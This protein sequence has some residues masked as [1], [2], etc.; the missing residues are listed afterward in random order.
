MG[1]SSQVSAGIIQELQVHKRQIFTALGVLVCP[2]LMMNY[3]DYK[4]TPTL[5]LDNRVFAVSY[6][7]WSLVMTHRMKLLKDSKLQNFMRINGMSKTAFIAKTIIANYIF[8]MIVGGVSSLR[9]ALY[10]SKYTS[11]DSSSLT[12]RFLNVHLVNAI[13]VVNLCLLMVELLPEEYVLFVAALWF[14]ILPALSVIESLEG[15]ISILNPF[16]S[17]NMNVSN[18][19]SSYYGETLSKMFSFAMIYFVLY[20]CLKMMSFMK[21]RFKT[22]VKQSKLKE[23][24]L[25]LM[26]YDHQLL[27][28]GDPE[29][30]IG[31][32]NNLSSAQYEEPTPLLNPKKVVIQVNE[33]GMRYQRT[34]EPALENVTFQIYEGE[35]F[36]LL[37]YN[38]AGKT[39]LLSILC[40]LISQTEGTFQYDDNQGDTQFLGFCSQENLIFVNNTIHENF[41]LM[42]RLKNVQQ[43]Q[44]N[45]R[46]E[47]LLNQFD[48]K[49]LQ[50]K[51]VSGLHIDER[52]KLSLALALLNNP[53]III[54]DEPTSELDV[55]TRRDFW[56]R[57]KELKQNGKT[58]IFTTQFLDDAEALADRVAILA[59]GGLY[60]LGSVDYMKKTFGTGYTLVISNS[61]NPA[62]LA[63]QASQ[64]NKLVEKILPLAELIS[65]TTLNILKYALSLSDRSKFPRLLKELES[66]PNIQ[67]NLQRTSLEDA[68]KGLERN[69]RIK[70]SK[71][72]DE[73]EN[74]SHLDSFEDLL[75][76]KDYE[77]GIVKQIKAVIFQRVC[78]FKQERNQLIF[79]IISTILSI[80]VQRIL[81][82]YRVV[83]DSTL[84]GKV[85]DVIN[86]AKPVMSFLIIQLSFL[87]LF[88]ALDMTR[89]RRK[90]QTTII[91]ILGLKSLSY[92]SGNL[93]FDLIVLLP[94]TLAFGVECIFYEFKEEALLMN[95]ARIILTSICIIMF[96][97]SCSSSGLGMNA[98]GLLLSIPLFGFMSYAIEV[99]YLIIENAEEQKIGPYL[100]Y[101]LIVILI[102]I[103]VLLSLLAGVFP[104][105]LINNHLSLLFFSCVIQFIAIHYREEFA[106]F[107]GLRKFEGTPI[108]DGDSSAIS[109]V[110]DLDSN[111]FIRQERER[112]FAQNNQDVINILG[113]EKYYA[114]YEHVRERQILK[115]IN[116]G[117]E[118]GQI[119]CLLGPN[120]SG[121]TL[122][123]DVLNRRTFL[124]L[125]LIKIKGQYVGRKSCSK[126]ITGACLQSDSHWDT[127][128]V[129]QNLMVIAYSRGMNEKEASDWTESLMRALDLKRHSSTEAWHLS[130]GTRRKLSVA[131]A[132]IGGPELVL[133]DSPTTGVDPAGRNQI[134]TLLKKLVKVK[135]ST[136][137][138]S[139][140]YT[141]DAELVADK[142]GIIVNGTMMT[143][144]SISALR[145]SHLM[146]FILIEKVAEGFMKNLIEI[147][148]GVI[149]EAEPETKDQ[150][151][152][153]QVP[154]T[155]MKFG[156]IVEQLE[157]LSTNKKISDFSINVKTLEQTFMAYASEQVK[158]ELYSKGTHERALY[159]KPTLEL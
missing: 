102:L 45:Q 38:G 67:I 66:I 90:D 156:R 121:K 80:L 68:F 154:S 76:K 113:G 110:D 146:H 85:Y 106:K 84:K 97:Y 65:E 23:L 151:V 104:G 139:T 142:L 103:T 55:V 40:G 128:S 155:A 109:D 130:A 87:V 120:H 129:K 35:I 149:P 2:I 11:S 81:D 44:F 74:K 78:R 95:L 33:I 145:K 57:I 28:N 16:V 5:L 36:C 51:V 153:F 54:L 79:L 59:N 93:I 114:P 123:F 6:F 30:F 12:I 71:N 137:L 14:S 42:A 69:F 152:T 7:A 70:D 92:Y 96:S 8:T 58:V 32:S 105:P 98:F 117:V 112:V 101:F 50:H 60:A 88:S 136:V 72:Q 116:F 83:P 10:F 29:S 1:F 122:I 27:L 143:L 82:A 61:V 94:L 53:N 56:E 89:N 77:T 132:L 150:G 13:A 20:L 119:F 73:Y 41:K 39:T 24:D 26:N 21:E 63:N 25:P 62:E 125:G 140:H 43:E 18:I 126:A 157:D 159:A 47:D 75:K 107:R 64:I 148:Q 52:K 158:P 124:D 118:K 17:L 108:Q 22:R 91:Q 99:I 144:G 111:D 19:A 138:I 115:N 46:V 147:V 131:M 31:R 34:T 3:N 86:P 49:K 134:W 127:L 9:G 100:T 133:L 48:L 15:Y 37:G 4:Q 141:E 135:G